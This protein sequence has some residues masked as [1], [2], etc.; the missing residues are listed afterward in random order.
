MRLPPFLGGAQGALDAR[1]GA[2]EVGLVWGY[3]AP[4]EPIPPRVFGGSRVTSRRFSGFPDGASRFLDYLRTRSEPDASRWI[5]APAPPPQPLDPDS[6]ATQ[7]DQ[8]WHAWVATGGT[9]AL[10]PAQY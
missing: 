4:T 3:F 2:V 10:F 6:E 7:S 5:Q 1:R 8:V 9:A